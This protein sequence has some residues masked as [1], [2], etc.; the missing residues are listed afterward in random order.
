MV[1]IY[2]HSER[3]AGAAVHG[4][5]AWEEAEAAAGREESK[6]GSIQCSS[7][8]CQQLQSPHSA[9]N[10]PILFSQAASRGW[11]SYHAVLYR[12]TLCFYEERK[13]T[14]RVSTEWAQLSW[15]IWLVWGHLW[16]PVLCCRAPHV[17]CLWTSQELSV[18][19][20][21]STPKNPTASGY[22]EILLNTSLQQR[23]YPSEINAGCGSSCDFVTFEVVIIL[24]WPSGSVMGLSI[25]LV[26]RHAFWWRNGWWKYKQAQVVKWLP[27][28]MCADS[29]MIWKGL[30]ICMFSLS[31]KARVNLHYR[32]Q[33]LTFQLPRKTGQV[34]IS[35]L[36]MI[37][38]FCNNVIMF[39]LSPYRK[40]S[41]C[42]ACH[43]LAKCH[44]SPQSDIAF[45]FPRGK[46]LA[47][48]QPKEIIVLTRDFTHLP[49]SHLWSV[50]EQSTVSSDGDCCGKTSA[51]EAKAVFPRELYSDSEHWS[52]LHCWL[53]N[54]PP[55]PAGV[56]R[57]SPLL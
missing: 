45:T 23:F 28:L 53:L 13:D 51:V 24:L 30:F 54:I 42:S 7:L 3:E 27:K 29:L 12:H 26:P 4:G 52:F 8:H 36:L 21:Q 10:T 31:Q 49:Q 19:L 44:C 50:D 22:G 9:A 11:N 17:A 41:L 38:F 39:C 32:A 35:K 16:S 47:S 56:Y 46:P 2:S 14:L 25:C 43:G 15:F 5:N 37:P 33:Q 1:L 55:E 40:S 57:I 34:I 20:H 48:A 18:H 6:E